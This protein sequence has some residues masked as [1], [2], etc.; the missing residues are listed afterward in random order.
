[1]SP[2]PPAP[3]TG[4]AHIAHE[5]FDDDSGALVLA[6]VAHEECFDLGTWPVL[7]ADPLDALT[8]WTA[9]SDLHLIGLSTVVE[10]RRTTTLADRGGHLVTVGDG[11]TPVATPVLVADALSRAL[12]LGTAPPPIGIASWIDRLWLDRLAQRVFAAEASL[13]PTDLL[14][15]HPLHASGFVAAD[16]AAL[17][18]AAETAA[19]CSRWSDLRGRWLGRVE[20][21]PRPP[22][23]AVVDDCDWFDDGSFVRRLLADLPSPQQLLDDLAML[24]PHPLLRTVLAGLAG[25]TVSEGRC[26]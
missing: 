20:P 21:A 6:V 26:R 12:G 24:L 2:H 19:R 1:M 25:T 5:E 18:A 16:P 15:L 23:G 9:P 4:L 11:D 3:I 22:G 8:G 14:A 13:Q 7:D 10:G 17:R